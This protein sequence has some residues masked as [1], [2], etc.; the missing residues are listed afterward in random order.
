[1]KNNQAG[2]V[3]HHGLITHAAFTVSLCV[4]LT[5]STAASA[6]SAGDD[7]GLSRDGDLSESATPTAAPL[8][9][10]W[11][12]LAGGSFNDANNWVSAVGPVVPGPL[13][14]AIFPQN[15]TQ[16]V[17][18]A[19]DVTTDQLF[20][21]DGTILFGLQ[22]HEY[23]TTSLELEGSF[24]VGGM[25]GQ[26]AHLWI[27]GGTLTSTSAS[28][29]R[30]NGSTGEVKLSTTSSQWNL[31][32]TLYVGNSG[33][34]TLLIEVGAVL[35]SAAAYVGR[36]AGA[37]GHTTVDGFDSMWSN[38]SNL[39]IGYE[40][41]G[42]LTISN[43]AVVSDDN[44]NIGY[45]A[46]SSGQVTV[47]GNESTWT[48]ATDLSVG[49]SGSGDLTITGGGKVSNQ[50]GYVGRNAGASGTVA[51]DGSTWTMSTL[52]VGYE[53][54]GQVQISN[55][56]SLSSGVGKIGEMEGSS[57]SVNV[58]GVGSTWYA[59]D[60]EIGLADGVTG[61]LNISA[62]GNVTSYHN[63]TV[64][65]REGSGSVSIDGPGSSMSIDRFLFVANAYHSTGS[66]TIRN[67]G[68]LSSWIALVKGD[69]VVDGAGST[70]TN[71]YVSF[72]GSSSLTISNGGSVTTTYT[73]E[74]GAPKTPGAGAVTVDG[75]G[76]TW[77]AYNIQIGTAGGGILTISD[78]GSVT[79]HDVVLYS[80][81]G[82]SGQSAILLDHGTITTVHGPEVEYGIGNGGTISGVGTIYSDVRN[83][84][85]ISPGNSPGEL[86][87]DGKLKLT[88]DSALLIDINGD[89]ASDVDKLTVTGAAEL[90]GKLSLSLMPGYVP[91]LGDSFDILTASSISGSFSS[92]DGVMV[93]NQLGLAVIYTA[94]KVTITA[95]VPGDANLDGIVNLSDLQDLGDNWHA[96]TGLWSKCN[97]NGDYYVD[98]AD[99]QALAD[100]WGYGTGADISFTQALDTVV[101]PEPAGLLLLGAGSVLLLRHA[102]RRYLDPELDHPSD[103]LTP[104]EVF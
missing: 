27:S 58:D 14:L 69:V 93:S 39:H 102:Q 20:V 32:D 23:A 100:N 97:F 44:G 35:S 49:E 96:T 71:E 57:G 62:G 89:Q 31:A 101:I 2:R 76:S 52:H 81:F 37:V 24:V 45:A 104:G 82:P 7:T 21:N 66:V 60:I 85:A 9:I 103:T 17:T 50:Q 91:D 55:G 34:G 48:H 22:G 72:S 63:V 6:D 15:A 46:G 29:G 10:Y 84:G 41:T 42:H 77:T 38:T 4:V 94:T 61:E 19:S 18:F 30:T 70:W 43:K 68:H 16:I 26:S 88:G 25:A 28:I 73:G 1:M 40:G 3:G 36:N 74:I 11:N 67:G 92:I 64:G 5:L 83:S 51:V 79:C 87:I 33:S 86:T 8:V 13:D 56:G 47:S 78:G 53:G 12:S 54:T 90:D 99:L 59:N 98:L 65:G 80:P 95:A 75:A